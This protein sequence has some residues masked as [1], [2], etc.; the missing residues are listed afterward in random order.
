LIQ[1]EVQYN[2]QAI[3]ETTWSRDVKNDNVPQ[4]IAFGEHI[5]ELMLDGS[6]LP[7]PS[8]PAVYQYYKDWVK[9]FSKETMDTNTWKTASTSN[10]FGKMM[11]KLW[12]VAEGKPVTIEGKKVAHYAFD[13]A[14][15]ADWISAAKNFEV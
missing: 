9:Q 4:Y 14:Q 11:T 7:K 10:S 5:H 6:V 1:P 15:L 12:G 3:P 2:R 8:K 13:T